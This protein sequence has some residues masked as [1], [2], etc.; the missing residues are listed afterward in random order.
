MTARA[1]EKPFSCIAILLEHR[2]ESVFVV[3]YGTYFKFVFH[4]YRFHFVIHLIP[5]NIG[6]QHKSIPD[7]KLSKQSDL[8]R[9]RGIFGV[10]VACSDR[11]AGGR[12]VL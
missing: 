11:L 5:P 2:M 1:D 7:L 3:T 4:L 10:Q 8:T 12:D 6:V 9:Q